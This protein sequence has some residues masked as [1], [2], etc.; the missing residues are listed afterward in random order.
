MARL[1]LILSTLSIGATVDAKLIVCGSAGAGG[2]IDLSGRGLPAYAYATADYSLTLDFG[3]EAGV[4]VGFW[5]CQA[6]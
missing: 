3:A 5:A 2:T 1:V 6:N 4:E